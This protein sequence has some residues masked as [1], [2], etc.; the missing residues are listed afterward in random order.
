MLTNL[1]NN[2]KKSIRLIVCKFMPVQL[3]KKINFLPRKPTFEKSSPNFLPTFYNH[4][5][6]Q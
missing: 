4:S 6:K 1:M 2:Q 3:K 5:S